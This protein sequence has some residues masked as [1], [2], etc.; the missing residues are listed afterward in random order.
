[1]PRGIMLRH[2]VNLAVLASVLLLTACGAQP[3]AAQQA[4]PTSPVAPATTAPAPAVP[5]LASKATAA[6]TTAAPA[7]P[8]TA[9]AAPAA[10]K[11]PAA[12]SSGTL[13]IAFSRAISVLDGVGGGVQSTNAFLQMYDTLV[14]LDPKLQ[15]RPGLAESWEAVNPTT[16]RFKLRQG[17]KFHGGEDFNADSVKYT[18]DR[19]VALQ[20]RY[21][22]ANNWLGGWPPSVEVESPYSV[23]IK[24]PN[25]QPAVPRLLS[26]VGMLPPSAANNPDFFK[27]ANGTGPFKFIEWT[28]G[29]RLVMEANPN[30]WR[31]APKIARLVFDTVTDQ[32]ARL[33]ALQAGEYEWVQDLPFERLKELVAAPNFTVFEANT[34][35][36]DFITFNGRAPKTS[37]I[38]DPK[39]RRALTYAIDG[40]AIRDTILAGKGELSKGPAPSLTV[41]SVD[42]GGYPKRDVAMAKKLLAEAGYNGAELTL[43]SNGSDILKELEITEAIVAQ[44]AEV[45]VPV[46]IEQLESAAFNQRRPTPNWDLAP[47]GVP[48]SF[49]G[50]SP[51]HYAQLKAQQGFT[52]AK[53]EQ[54]LEQADAPTT[55]PPQRQE[56]LQQAMKAMWDDVPYLWSVGKVSANGMSRKLQGFE[57]IPVNWV[58][59]RS[60]S[61]GE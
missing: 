12:T 25:P 14:E 16:W 50:E 29:Q 55:S 58:F 4:A 30:Y 21:T 5:P 46:R 53:V 11:A 32:G 2:V 8:T 24:T 33:A 3:Q 40:Q 45:G 18:I 59:F 47:N 13:R 22:Y 6:P 43:I 15:L 49:T 38:A 48:G 44:L 1:M 41:G 31:G 9:A 60:A 51:Y 56:L 27:K 26:R 52:S 19:L 57:F 17:V 7:A 39:I 61:L 36:L 42:A 37:P 28:V 10:P 34:I 35:G 20:P 54:L 23:L